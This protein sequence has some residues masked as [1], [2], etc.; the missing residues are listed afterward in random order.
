MQKYKLLEKAM[1]D[2]PAG[3][4]ARFNGTLPDHTSTGIFRITDINH[5]GDIQVMANNGLDCFYA[6][7]VWATPIPL[8]SGKNVVT[9]TNPRQFKILMDH[10]GEKGW[11]GIGGATAEYLYEYLNNSKYPKNISYHDRFESFVKGEEDE[12]QEYNI[13]SFFEFAEFIGVDVPVFV[14][15]SN[16]GV[17]M[18]VG[19][20]CYLAF[21]DD[22]KMRYKNVPAVISHVIYSSEVFYSEDNAAKWIE[23]QTKIIHSKTEKCIEEQEPTRADDT[24]IIIPISLIESEIQ[25]Y[26][27][28]S[29]KVQNEDKDFVKAYGDIR[30]YGYLQKLLTESKK[31]K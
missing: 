12:Y 28:E 18:Y 23:E 3:T 13:T 29:V 10:Y 5:N 6:D 14:L 31:T 1:R 17:D 2:Y 22:S 20:D 11:K 24:N 25:K 15:T 4:I 7:G 9:V 30:V 8:L 27:D 19:D 26:K 16:D 21:L